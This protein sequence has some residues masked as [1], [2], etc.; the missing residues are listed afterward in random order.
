MKRAASCLTV[1]IMLACFQPL[2]AQRASYSSGTGAGDAPFYIGFS[3]GINNECGLL[4][5][6]LELPVGN[7]VSLGAGIG[8][9]S[10]GYK[11]YGEARY[12]FDADKK[13]WALG[14]GLSYSTGAT[15]MPLS[16][17][18]TNSNSEKV[19]LTLGSVT[20][21]FFT[22]YKFYNLGRSGK[23]RFYL[24]MGY[25][26]P[27]GAAKYTVMSGQ[28]LTQNSENVLKIISPGGLEFGL[29]FSFG[30]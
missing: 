22:A 21:L 3:T 20:N 8:E 25:A 30:L 27:L 10:W 15:N 18:T 2:Q 19:T 4:G 5:L 23:N 26:A 17:E 1:F 9:G 13:G 6:N 14:A 7:A 11:T 12:Y 29:G 16:L 28:T 24:E